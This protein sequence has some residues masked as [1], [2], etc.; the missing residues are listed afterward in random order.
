MATEW[1]LIHFG[2]LTSQIKDA[3]V[4]IRDTLAEVGLWVRLVL[5]IPVTPG[6][7]A[8]HGDT[9]IFSGMPKGKSWVS[10]LWGH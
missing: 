3:N 7:A 6:G 1:E 9:R 2:L 5:K 8:A 10:L 4:S